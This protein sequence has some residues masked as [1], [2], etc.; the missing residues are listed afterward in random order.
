MKK[1]NFD[2]ANLE[3]ADFSGQD[4]AGASF[5]EADLTG[6]N[7]DGANL[8]GVNFGRAYLTRASMR[9][10]NL[11]G[12]GF[13]E[14]TL[15]Y[16]DLTDAHIDIGG[17]TWNSSSRYAK[18]VRATIDHGALAWLGLHGSLH[19]A[20]LTGMF[21]L[22][23]E[24][25]ADWDCFKDTPLVHNEAGE[26]GYWWSVDDK[27]FGHAALDLSDPAAANEFTRSEYE[28]LVRGIEKGE[29][30]GQAELISFRSDYKRDQH[31]ALKQ[32]IQ[33]DIHM[34]D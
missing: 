24:N 22:V 29:A 18:F 28:A 5:Y 26:F 23:E 6:A 12:A 8:E 10:A 33:G 9:G 15:D 31:E 7:C 4:L 34:P 14:V 32:A 20:D 30:W 27:R 13:Y 25:R 19:G 2:N 17:D 11:D 21:I 16:A 3:G 1:K